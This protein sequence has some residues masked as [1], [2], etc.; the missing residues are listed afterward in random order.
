MVIY[1]NGSADNA[2]SVGGLTNGD[3]YYVIKT[4]DTTLETGLFPGKCPGRQGHSIG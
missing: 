1:S 2:N 3:T 4:S